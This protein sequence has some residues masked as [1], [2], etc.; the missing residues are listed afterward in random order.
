LFLFEI[1][2]TN[3][4]LPVPWPWSV[5][6]SALP[7]SRAI[8]DL[9]TGLFFVG[10]ALYAMVGIPWALGSFLRGGRLKPAQIA[11]AFL[12][13]PYAHFVFSRADLD[14]L[15][16][17]IFPSLIGLLAVADNPIGLR[18]WLSA[19]ILCGA[20]LLVMLPKRP[21]YECAVLRECVEV[22][23]A[24]DRLRVDPAT[25][26]QVSLV[27]R[28]VAEHPGRS[29]VVVP[30]SPGAYAMTRSRSPIWS[31]Y[32]LF[33]RSR[34]FQESEIERMRAA[35]PAFVLVSDHAL[36]GRD[37]LRFSRTHTTL[38]QYVRERFAEAPGYATNPEWHVLVAPDRAP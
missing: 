20:S 23:I 29:F 14:H 27:H 3:L 13:L 33:P 36:D 31:I 34:S 9:V 21:I 17:G 25:A 38:Y 22:E 6:F 28:L 4:P 1:R 11:S 32:A 24:R 35:D 30:H 18:R 10:V 7:A 37:E 2:A 12:A 19:L 15:A 16:Q 5:P 26:E 8:H